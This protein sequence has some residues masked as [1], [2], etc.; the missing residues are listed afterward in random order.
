[1]LS[2]SEAGGSENLTVTVNVPVT[3]SGSPAVRIGSG[4]TV[5]FT[6]VAVA[7]SLTRP[8]GSVTVADSVIWP[9][10]SEDRSRL[11]PDEP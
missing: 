4:R 1:M 7:G 3:G 5:S 6:K 2:T 8:A 10:G 9:S 11:G